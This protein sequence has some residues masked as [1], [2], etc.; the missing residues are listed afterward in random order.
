[1]TVEHGP[2]G[3]RISAQMFDKSGA[4]LGSIT[5]N[6]YE[7]AKETDLIVEH[8]ADLATLVV[9]NPAGDELF[10]IHYL[11]EHAMRVCGIFS[12]PRT[13]FIV[14]ID[15][16]TIHPLTGVHR[17]CGGDSLIGIMLGG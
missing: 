5:Q 14:T 3:M 15:N 8:S 10:Y 4:L 7:I 2:N 16:K 9:H 1:M 11:N 17:S 12:C 13:H 6:G